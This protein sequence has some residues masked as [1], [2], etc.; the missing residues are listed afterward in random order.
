MEKSLKV[1]TIQH[2]KEECINYFN[3]GPLRHNLRTP[4]GETLLYYTYSSITAS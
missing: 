2:Q 1:V 4:R 3:R